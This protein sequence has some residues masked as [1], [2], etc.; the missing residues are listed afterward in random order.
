MQNSE[1]VQGYIDEATDIIRTQTS[2]FG[3][4][5]KKSHPNKWRL[6]VDLSSQRGRAVN[7]GVLGHLCS[8]LYP[9]AKDAAKMARSLGKGTPLAKIDLKNAYRMLPVHPH[10]LWLLAVN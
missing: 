4:I 2:S 7:D 5:P 8:L 3:V 9:S 10:D 6:I 1:V